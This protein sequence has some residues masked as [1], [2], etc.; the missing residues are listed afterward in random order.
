MAK[1]R[2]RASAHIQCLPGGEL[3]HVHVRAHTH[4]HTHTQVVNLDCWLLKNLGRRAHTLLWSVLEAEDLFL[5][6]VF[7]W[8]NLSHNP[9]VHQC[10]CVC[11]CV[12][13][14]AWVC[15][16]SSWYTCRQCDGNCDSGGCWSVWS[17][18]DTLRLITWQCALS[19]SSEPN[20]SGLSVW[21]V[22]CR[23]SCVRGGDTHALHHLYGSRV[24]GRILWYKN[25]QACAYPPAHTTWVTESMHTTHTSHR[26]HT[27]T[28]QSQSPHTH[29][30]LSYRLFIER[31]LEC[32]ITI[33]FDW[34][35]LTLPSSSSVIYDRSKFIWVAIYSK[36]SEKWP[37][38][39]S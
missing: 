32:K 10:V 28:H 29:T 11:T 25:L 18:Q 7:M 30:P 34:P 24:S 22:S 17:Y 16:Y 6:P 37:V 23:P 26:V 5:Q 39:S 27:L 21:G 9:Q 35:L 33:S 31:L 15:A 36:W 38:T 12:C 1:I 4:T 14:H 8:R 2:P 13:V 19:V 20:C 3:W